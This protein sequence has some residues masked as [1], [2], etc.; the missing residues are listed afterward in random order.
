[1]I[2]WICSF[3]PEFARQALCPA[4]S[5][6]WPLFCTKLAGAGFAELLN[7]AKFSS[8]I[9]HSRHFIHGLMCIEQGLPYTGPLTQW[10]ETTFAQHELFGKAR[11]A[12]SIK[13]TACH[14]FTS[15]LQ[16]HTHTAR[17]GVV[18]VQVRASCMAF[19]PSASEKLLSHGLEVEPQTKQE[20]SK[21][22]CFTAHSFAQQFGL[23]PYKIQAV[24]L[25]APLIPFLRQKRLTELVWHCSWPAVIEGFPPFW[26]HLQSTAAAA[27]APDNIS[28]SSWE[29]WHNMLQT[30]RKLSCNIAPADKQLQHEASLMATQIEKV[31]NS[32]HAFFQNTHTM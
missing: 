8:E 32:T 23:D 18:E 5:I 17:N 19:Y 10:Q 4:I 29:I 6:Q 22:M 3:D 13:V 16:V 12:Y 30:L 21:P 1:M 24:Q 14:W 2:A 11:D 26:F 15:P 7:H 9:R 27:Q 28:P 20:C 25:A 31:L